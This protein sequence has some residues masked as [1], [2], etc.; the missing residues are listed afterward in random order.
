MMSVGKSLP[1]FELLILTILLSES[2]RGRDLKKALESRRGRNLNH[3]Q[4][5]L[6]LNKMLK[7]GVIDKETMPPSPVRGGRRHF[8]YNITEE[9]EAIVSHYKS[10]IGTTVDS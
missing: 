7:K 1:T 6:S 8:K 4:L 2:C 3:S 5:A 9:G 10:L